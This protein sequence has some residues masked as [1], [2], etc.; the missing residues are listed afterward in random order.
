MSV[1]D[2]VRNPKFSYYPDADKVRN[3][4]FSYYPDADKVRNPNSATCP[5]L[6]ARNIEERMVKITLKLVQ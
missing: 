6:I 5:V 3:P 4:K 2:R 1:V